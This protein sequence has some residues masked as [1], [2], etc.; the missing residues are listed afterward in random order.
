MK[1]RRAA[2]NAQINEPEVVVGEITIV[3]IQPVIG[4]KIRGGI[5]RFNY[6]AARNP[7]SEVPVLDVWQRLIILGEIILG[8][9]PSSNGL[10]EGGVL[11]ARVR[12]RRATVCNTDSLCAVVV[13]KVIP[14]DFALVIC[15]CPELKRRPRFRQTL[16]DHNGSVTDEMVAEEVDV[17]GR[18][19]KAVDDLGGY[20]TKVVRIYERKRSE[21]A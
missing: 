4:E 1:G 6:A 21:A 7:T 20:P 11:C 13:D 8:G 18:V 16:S 3:V 10:A 5:K 12:G 15:T 2:L 19:G 17:S 9:L 14:I